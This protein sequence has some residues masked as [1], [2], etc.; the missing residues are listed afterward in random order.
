MNEKC[1]EE[2][3]VERSPPVVQYQEASACKL[4]TGFEFFMRYK[5][6]LSYE[7]NG[8]MFKLMKDIHTYCFC[9][10]LED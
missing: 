8:K 1:L 2:I 3:E 4:E 10:I 9:G 7:Y 5:E 6:H